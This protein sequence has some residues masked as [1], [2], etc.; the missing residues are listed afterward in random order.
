MTLQR[1]TT[2]DAPLAG[3]NSLRFGQPFEDYLALPGEHF[4][5]LKALDTSPYHYLSQVRPKD[6]KALRQGRALH[7][8]VLTPDVPGVAVYPGPVRNGKAYDAF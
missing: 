2:L 6:T 7:A 1:T 5:G 3:G 4:S 8:L